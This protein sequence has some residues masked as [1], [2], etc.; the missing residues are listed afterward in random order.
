MDM[1]EGQLLRAKKALPNN[2]KV[3]NQLANYWRIKGETVK[4]ID[5]FRSALMI[6]PVNPDALHDLGRLLYSLQY[7]EDAIFLVRRALDAQTTIH[8]RWRLYFTLG[9]I[10]RAYGRAQQSIMYFQLALELNPYHEPILTALKNLR[11]NM[12]PTGGKEK[13]TIFIILG[14]VCMTH[15]CSLIRFN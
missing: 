4:S 5:C 1:L 7:Y 15:I 11:L 10:Y 14:L 2:A 6:D 3:Y 12:K 8:G 9:E 13:Y